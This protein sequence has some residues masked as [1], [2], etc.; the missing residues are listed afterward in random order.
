[1]MEKAPNVADLDDLAP[2]P[3]RLGAAVLQKNAKASFRSF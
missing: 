1:M 3:D 2:V